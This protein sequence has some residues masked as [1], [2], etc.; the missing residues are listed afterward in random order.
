APVLERGA[1][2]PDTAFML[3]DLGEQQAAL[4]WLLHSGA[5]VLSVTPMRSSLEE[6]FMATAER[7][8][9]EP[10]AAGERASVRRWPTPCSSP[11]PRSARPFATASSPA[12]RSAGCC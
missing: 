8:G 1:A 2:G 5:Q 4:A 9:T 12:S 10:S 6:L 7:A 3:S 11:T